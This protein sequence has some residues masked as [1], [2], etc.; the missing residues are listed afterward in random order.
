MKSAVLFLVLL[1]SSFSWAQVL[2]PSSEEVKFSY[3]A[4]FVSEDTET[5]VQELAH[6][7]A[8]YLFGVMHSTELTESFGLNWDKV[9]GI[10]SPHSEIQIR[11]LSKFRSNGSLLVKYIAH[12]KLL[13]HKKVAQKTLVQKSLPV[14]LPYDMANVYDASCTDEHYDSEGDYW[15]F[16]NPYREGCEHLTEEPLTKRV[17]LEISK[18]P[19]AKTDAM[20]RLDLVRGNNDNGDVFSIYVI[21]GFNEDTSDNDDGRINFDEFNEYLREENFNEKILRKT[22]N[23][24]LH[25]FT[26]ALRLENGK[27]IN[28]EI[29]NLL[30]HTEIDRKTKTFA[31]FMREAVYHA[32]VIFYAGHS[33]L[34]GNLDIASLEEIAG[35]FVFNAKKK[36]IFFFDS[37]SSYSYYLSPFAA[38]KTKAK[39]DIM[40]NGLASYFH[41]T[42]ATTK[43]FFSSLLTPKN[44]LS[45]L[46]ILTAMEKPLHGGSYLLTVGGL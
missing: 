35:K 16:W 39:I 30:A 12:G 5:D 15:Y 4:E 18:G 45:W 22:E 17:S 42:E 23:R 41:T 27:T 8:D 7:H 11:I 28:V 31:Q 1:I 9:G 3:K 38:E 36:Q 32:D 21:H 43:A 13:L 33:G 29:R 40:T 19:K 10:G 34:G 25:L 20:A 37:C 24:P 44:D 46:E 2:G 6:A 14:H 26:K